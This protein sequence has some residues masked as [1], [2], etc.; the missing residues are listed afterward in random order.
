MALISLG[1]NLQCF[2]A[3]SE[4]ILKKVKCSSLAT[5]HSNTSMKKQD[6]PTVLKEKTV[7]QSLWTIFCSPVDRYK[8]SCIVANTI[9]LL[10]YSYKSPQPTVRTLS[11]K[12]KNCF[13]HS[14]MCWM[15][16]HQVAQVRQRMED[17]WHRNKT[18]ITCTHFF[19]SSCETNCL[20]P[21]WT[22][23]AA[24]VRHTLQ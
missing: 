15:P 4:I 1:C 7:F 5:L 18:K 21:C 16:F 11:K 3:I 8:C 9:I 24:L 2:K 14:S 17:I 23:N 12:R 19:K 6:P 22:G 13:A 10:C 20:N